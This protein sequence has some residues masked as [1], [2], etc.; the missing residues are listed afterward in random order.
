MTSSAVVV[1][2]TRGRLGVYV[3]RRRVWVGKQSQWAEAR[4]V[5]LFIDSQR[6]AT[7]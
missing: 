4:K 2:L 5:A 6:E 3:D 7:R 1:N